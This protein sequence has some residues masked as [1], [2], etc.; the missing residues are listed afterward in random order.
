LEPAFTPAPSLPSLSARIPWGIGWLLLDHLQEFPFIGSRNVCCGP[1][2]AGGGGGGGGGVHVTKETGRGRP[3]PSKS[4]AHAPTATVTSRRERGG[5][6]ARGKRTQAPRL[7]PYLPPAPVR[8]RG[9]AAEVR[10]GPEARRSRRGVCRGSPSSPPACSP[11]PEP[12]SAPRLTHCWPSLLPG[13]ESDGEA[14]LTSRRGS[15]LGAG[16]GNVRGPWD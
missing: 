5:A 11:R 16:C 2:P 7:S 12:P 8:V 6:S 14:V 4:G 10:A 9:A 1:N 13:P 3:P 15:C